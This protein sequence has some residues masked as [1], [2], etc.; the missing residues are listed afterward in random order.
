MAGHSHWKNVKRTKDSESKKRSLA[1]S[2]IGRVISLAA[3]EGG[4]EIEKN[5]TLKN[6][7][8]KAKKMNIPK[9]NIEKAIKKGTGE[10]KNDLQE[11]I[12]ES[13]GPGGIAII[14][15]G[16]TDNINRTYAEFKRI[17]TQYNGKIA[18]PGS[19]KWMFDRKGLI[20]LKY[21]K[22]VESVEMIIIDSGAQD[23]EKEN[24]NFIVYTD[25]EDLD[26]VKNYIESKNLEIDLSFL[27]WKAKDKIKIEN[28]DKEKLIK[29]LE[30][31]SDNED[32]QKIYSNLK[33]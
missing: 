33:K 6:I 5:P 18:E 19:V 13:Y 9:E 14:I 7:I 16:I 4:G 28:S 12:F 25:P 3:K 32:V 21:Q 20:K 31:L 15:E 10:L 27:S 17:I 29:L 30:N 22:N 2:K 11:F 23:F 26:R 24:G 8:E 1:F